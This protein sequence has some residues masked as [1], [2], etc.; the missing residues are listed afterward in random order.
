VKTLP[1]F[2]A[3]GVEIEYMIVDRATLEVR[4]LADRVLWDG[5]E[6]VDE[7]PMG[8]ISWSNEL[9]LHVVELKTNGP[10]AEL[11]P[12]PVEFG[13]AVGQVNDRLAPHGAMLLP[14]AMHPFMNPLRDT[15]LWPHANDEI[16]RAFDRIFDC[17]GHG[18]SN[19]QSTHLNLPFANDD[20]LARLHRAIRLWLPLLPALTA[21]SPVVEGILTETLDSRL[22]AYRDNC[23]RVPEVSGGVVPIDI[24][25]RADY[26]ARI[27]E[28][29]YRALAPHDPEGL[30]RHEWANA[31]G[32]I[33]RFDRMAVEIRVLDCQEHPGADLALLALIT[34]VL[35]D[36]V[37]RDRRGATAPVDQGAL[38]DLFWRCAAKGGEATVEDPVHLA[39][40]GWDAPVAVGALWRQAV[41]RLWAEGSAARRQWGPHVEIVLQH[42]NLAQRVVRDLGDPRP[43]TALDRAAIVRTFSRLGECL[44]D[45]R[46][47][48]P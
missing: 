41:D 20:E 23:R 44:R 10:A 14:T 46:P 31:R 11:G 13:K 4:P 47:F 42:G 1:L 27:L 9:A 43:G 19:L 5:T 26:E 29:I 2:S 22:F 33:V 45:G 15:V 37:E 34:A 21:S 30:L 24:A 16:Y 35:R 7:L 32:A 36:Q 48:L 28:P 6:S 8:A 3:H 25:S 38:Q 18:W 17:R 40:L 39:A 12:L